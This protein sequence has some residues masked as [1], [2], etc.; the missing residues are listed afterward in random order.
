[1]GRPAKRISHAI[2]CQ[3]LQQ[4]LAIRVWHDRS[5]VLRKFLQRSWL[6]NDV[7]TLPRRRRMGP[8]HGRRV[9][10][11]FRLR[12]WLGFGL[13][14]GMDAISLRHLGFPSRIRLGLA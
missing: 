7:A 14:M 4:L 3:V 9:G 8:V 5:L 11:Q 10:L 12:I 6:R 1:M 2:C 13:S